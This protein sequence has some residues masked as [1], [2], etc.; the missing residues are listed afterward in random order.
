MT[1]RQ[2]KPEET[3]ALRHEVLW[4]DKP[5]AYVIL[6]DDA[7]GRHFG[8][9]LAGDLV[10]VLSLFVEN[11]VARF[12]KFATRPD[13]Q[14]QGIGTRLLNQVIEDA[15]KQ[16]AHTLWCDARLSAADF[17]RRFGMEPEG[18]LFYK[19]E[20]PYSKFVLEL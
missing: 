7:K 9:F 8:A 14:R 13:C 1:I 3:Y 18:E 2:I 5:V 19:G 16:G 12:R 15:R 11:G 10:A 4:P 17:Y 6:D 20:I